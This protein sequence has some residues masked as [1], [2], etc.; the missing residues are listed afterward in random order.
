M[1]MARHR[2]EAQRSVIDFVGNLV[3]RVA[4]LP[5]GLP[6]ALFHLAGRLVSD[7]F[8]VRRRVASG[9]SPRLLGLPLQLVDLSLELVLVHRAL[10]M[11]AFLYKFRAV[12]R[13]RLT[14]TA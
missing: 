10:L 3:E 7:P 4:D 13:I 2:H 1:P 8:V 14:R 6:E 9:L 5:A 12:S 11:R